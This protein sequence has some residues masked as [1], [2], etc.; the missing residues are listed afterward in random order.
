MHAC[1]YATTCKDISEPV[2]KVVLLLEADGYKCGESERQ[3]INIEINLSPGRTFDSLAFRGS[4]R[5]HNL[6]LSTFPT[7]HVH[8]FKTNRGQTLHKAWQN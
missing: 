3:S 4:W 8:Q 6:I 5:L 2:L 7:P 1:L